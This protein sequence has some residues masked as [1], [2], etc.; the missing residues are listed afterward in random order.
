MSK[1]RGQPIHPGEILADELEAISMTGAD[2]AV[3]LGVP[4]NRI[5]QILNESRSL[6]A[7]T[8]MRLSKFFGT[9]PDFWLNLQS[10][11]ELD[12]IRQS[13]LKLDHII[14]F[15]EDRPSYPV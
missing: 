1:E 13:D 10:S 6:T 7:D 3:K 2:L 14:P 8:A 12:C 4:K 11:Y 9:S 15:S 5:Y